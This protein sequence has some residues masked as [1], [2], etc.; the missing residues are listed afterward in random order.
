MLQSSTGCTQ[1][2]GHGC[3]STEH[4]HLAALGRITESVESEKLHLG[5]Y[6]KSWEFAPGTTIMGKGLKQ[7]YGGD[8][9]DNVKK[10]G[11]GGFTAE[12]WCETC[13][14]DGSCRKKLSF[15]H[16]EVKA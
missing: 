7:V 15:L 16:P 12:H 8:G 6:Y 9:S 11:L 13:Y 4:C 1:D 14:A 2:A 10:K 5:D 3:Q